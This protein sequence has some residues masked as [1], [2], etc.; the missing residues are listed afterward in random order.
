[1]KNELREMF[2][3]YVYGRFET[4]TRARVEQVMENIR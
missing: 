2:R 1:M 3:Q 4:I